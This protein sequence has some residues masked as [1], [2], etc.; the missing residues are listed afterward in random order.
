MQIFEILVREHF[1]FIWVVSLCPLS[2]HQLKLLSAAFVNI[3]S[4]VVHRLFHNIQHLIY[5]K[6]RKILWP[7][8]KWRK[9]N[10][11]RPHD[12]ILC[13]NTKIIYCQ[14]PQF[15]NFNYS[16]LNS[17]RNGEEFIF[18]TNE[19]LKMANDGLD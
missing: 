7:L 17:R 13:C 3:L 16:D 14:N 6:K 4:H 5:S 9:K 8:K 11:H 19:I 10:S 15:S 18:R 2:V 12:P 1:R